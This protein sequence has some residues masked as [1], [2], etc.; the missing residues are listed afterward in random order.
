MS[1][2]LARVSVYTDPVLGQGSAVGLLCFSIFLL[3]ITVVH[4]ARI[5]WKY[6]C[7]GR[8]LTE[9]VQEIFSGK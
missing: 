4:V 5:Y 7:N 1:E 9:A 3:V 2:W 6:C 8:N